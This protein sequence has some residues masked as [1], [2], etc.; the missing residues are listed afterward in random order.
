MC[1]GDALPQLPG[2]E[3]FGQ[4]AQRTTPPCVDVL[5]DPAPHQPS[6]VR[7]FAQDLVEHGPAV[8]FAKIDVQH[9]Q[10]EG[11]G[12]H[13]L[14]GQFAGGRDGALVAGFQQDGVGK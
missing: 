1:I 4:H 13:R 6:L 11:P 12:T 10:V 14:Q 7:P 8:Q 9:D 2:V 3:G 5:R